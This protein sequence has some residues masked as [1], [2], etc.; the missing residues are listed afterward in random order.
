MKIYRKLLIKKLNN[1]MGEYDRYD[2]IFDEKLN[3]DLKDI[4]PLNNS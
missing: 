3:N 2:S 4:I 1:D